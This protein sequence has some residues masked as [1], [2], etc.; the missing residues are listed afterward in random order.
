MAELQKRRKAMFHDSTTIASLSD[1][2]QMLLIRA[3][4]KSD[5]FELLRTHT[6]MGFLGNPS[7]GG[8][9]D[10]VGWKQIGFEDQ[11]TYQHP[12]GYYD[13]PGNEK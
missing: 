9:R 2:R 11:M 6:V 3:I 12:F 4:E 10:K 8:N 7:Y 5:F 13:I 1:Q